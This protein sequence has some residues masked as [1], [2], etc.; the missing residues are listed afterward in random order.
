MGA[1]LAMDA[2][3]VAADWRDYC[4][5]RRWWWREVVGVTRAWLDPDMLHP[6]LVLEKK[7][8]IA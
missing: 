6:T 2:V 7:L 3:G 8:P 1:T 4:S 5:V